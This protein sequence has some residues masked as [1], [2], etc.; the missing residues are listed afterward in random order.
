MVTDYSSVFFDYSVLGRP[1]YFYMYDL[2][3]Y[4]EEHGLQADRL[5]DVLE[6]LK[7]SAKSC[8]TLD[9][10]KQKMNRTREELRTRGERAGTAVSTLHAAKGCEYRVVFI[11]DVNEGIIPW[12]NAACAEDL[13]EERRMFYVGMTRAKD[14]LHICTIRKRH[15]KEM[16]PSRFL[17][18]LVF[19]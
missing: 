1:T 2:K 13:E 7:E 15:E 11:A 14:R 8:R 19:K 12:H 4:A 3:E 5:T 9:E 10:W 6:E 18:G 16:M 17:S